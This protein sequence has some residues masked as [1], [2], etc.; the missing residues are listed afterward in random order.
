[1]NE[2]TCQLCG[3][4]EVED[5][6]H[7]LLKCNIFNQERIIMLNIVSQCVI[8][9]NT[10]SDAEQFVILMSDPSICKV[11]ARACHE[12]LVKRRKLLYIN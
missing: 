3:T 2:R 10:L 1:M 6:M 5:E 11:T 8:D 7:M 9:F 12:M 4:N